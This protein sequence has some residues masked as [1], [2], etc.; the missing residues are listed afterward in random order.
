M[1]PSPGH[2]RNAQASPWSSC[3][4]GPVPEGALP[5]LGIALSPPSPSLT[6]AVEGG[7]SP[8]CPPAGEARWS[9]S[10]GCG[11]L[12]NLSTAS[13]EASSIVASAA[14]QETDCEQQ[15]VLSSAELPALTRWCSSFGCGYLKNHP[16]ASNVT[17]PDVARV[18]GLYTDRTQQREQPGADLLALT[19]WSAPFGCGYLKNHLTAST[20]A[21]S[22]VV[23]ASGLGGLEQLGHVPKEM[24]DSAA[25]A[26]A[27]GVAQALLADSRAAPCP[28][29]PGVG[30]VVHGLVSA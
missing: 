25:V 15:R 19:R 24:L 12:K 18:G 30:Q 14:G 23:W 5:F 20:V 28:L 7:V 8:S 4:S 10:P 13:Y 11:Y 16:T 9:S 1:S 22:G 3:P 6:L 21:T 26:T 27:K 2:L 17:A 29:A